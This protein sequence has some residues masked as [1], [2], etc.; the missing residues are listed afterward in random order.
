M[1][2]FS[3][4]LLLLVLT[5]VAI[6]NEAIENKN[7]SQLNEKLTNAGL[8]SVEESRCS[9]YLT[10]MILEKEEK[11]QVGY[12]VSFSFLL[13]SFVL[14]CFLFY[15]IISCS[16]L[17]YFILLEEGRA[18]NAFFPDCIEILLM[19]LFQNI[20][21]WHVSQSAFFLLTNTLSSDQSCSA[22]WSF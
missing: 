4:S 6:I 13:V 16:I 12:V 22:T 8:T 10:Q 5:A 14:F 7:S 17:F 18:L 3:Y 2:A 15:F 20:L 1:Q 19:L 21:F 11:A 9:R